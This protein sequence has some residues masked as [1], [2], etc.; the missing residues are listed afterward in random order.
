MRSVE[1]NEKQSR[2]TAQRTLQISQQPST[3]VRYADE[4]KQQRIL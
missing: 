3:R 4:S 1:Q 2:L